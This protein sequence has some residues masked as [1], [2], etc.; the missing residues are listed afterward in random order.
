METPASD[1]SFRWSLMC[2]YWCAVLSGGRT[3]SW[4]SAGG[5]QGVLR[6]VDDGQA[7]PF[8]GTGTPADPFVAEGLSITVA[9]APA[10]GDRVLIAPT[11]YGAESIARAIDDPQA[12]AMAAPTRSLAD[13]GNIGNG[14]ISPTTVV[15][16]TDPGLLNT[17]TIEFTGP[18]TYSINGA[19]A[20]AYTA[21]DPITINGSG[22]TISGTPSAGDRFTIEA[23]TGCKRRRLDAPDPAESRGAV[24]DSRECGK[25]ATR[26]VRCQPRRRSGESPEVPAGL[27][28]GGTG[29]QHCEHLV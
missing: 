7:V 21:G 15:D 25:R 26:E 20:F 27:P 12:I 23:N 9:G 28:G 29:R 14:T 1:R 2:S 16:R 13:L 6:R 22:F 11:R 3:A 24:R 18:N 10:A 8:S 17:A 19:G 4:G 5:G